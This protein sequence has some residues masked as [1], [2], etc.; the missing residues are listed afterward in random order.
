MPPPVGVGEDALG[1]K[2]VDLLQPVQL[3]HAHLT[4]A[5]CER[6]FARARTSER[7]RLWTLHKAVEF[8]TA[9]ILRAPSSLR[10]ALD[11]ARRGSGGYPHV[12]ATPQAFF[13]RTKGLRWTF[14]RDVFRALLDELLPRLP[15]RF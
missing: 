10:Q 14:F 6:V 3:L 9:V 8:W 4:A 12:R 1:A 13:E 15:Q 11:E 5:L 7:R 2:L